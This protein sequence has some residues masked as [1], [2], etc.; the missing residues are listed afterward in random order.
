MMYINAAVIPNSREFS[1]SSAF[2][3]SKVEESH[4]ISPLHYAAVEMTRVVQP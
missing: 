2:T 3:S 4:E 1:L